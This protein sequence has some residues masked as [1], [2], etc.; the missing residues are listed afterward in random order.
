VP[1][2]EEELRLLEQMERALVAED[3]KLASTLRGSTPHRGARRRMILGGLAIVAGIVCLVAAVLLSQPILGVAGF[4]VMLGGAALAVSS[5]KAPNPIP[6]TTVRDS[7]RSGFGVVDGG[8][9][10]RRPRRSSAASSGSF[11]DRMEQR[12]RRRKDQGF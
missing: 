1:L 10:Q 2:S 8:A 4:V 11:M 3:P 9:R 7:G 5:V 6:P 12:W